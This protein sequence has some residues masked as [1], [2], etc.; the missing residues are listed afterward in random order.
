VSSMEGISTGVGVHFIGKKGE[1]EGRRDEDRGSARERVKGG[2]NSIDGIHQWGKVM[3][4]GEN[5]GVESPLTQKR[6]VGAGVARSRAWLA[7]STSG[8]RFWA[9]ARSAAAA[10]GIGR[11]LAA[12]LVLGV[13]WVAGV[14]LAG[15]QGHGSSWRRVGS[16][17]RSWGTRRGRDRARLLAAG[18]V[19]LASRRGR[20]GLLPCDAHGVERRE[21]GER[22]LSGRERD[23]VATATREREQGRRLGLG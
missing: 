19:L 10:V 17:G 14:G 18:R 20:P 16:R 6:M 15:V 9:R 11:L 23:W 21:G 22:V 1:V 5:G 8:R 7:S 12:A 4:E 3:G 2:I 13:G